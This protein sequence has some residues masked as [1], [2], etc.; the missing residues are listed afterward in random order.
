MASS[1]AVALRDKCAELTTL[2]AAYESGEIAAASTLGS[3]LLAVVKL[4]MLLLLTLAMVFLLG[5]VYFWRHYLEYDW[6]FFRMPVA[7]VVSKG[8]IRLVEWQL[9][10]KI[11]WERLTVS[12]SPC[13]ITFYSVVIPN[14]N[15]QPELESFEWGGPSLLT[16]GR[17]HALGTGK[18]CFL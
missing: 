5:F 10:F 17:L 4:N 6:T 1:G 3:N 15:L 16:I 18:I 7:C 9:P 12:L 13:C 11:C 14:P 2:L 8:F